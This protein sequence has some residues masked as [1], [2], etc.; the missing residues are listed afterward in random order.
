M[1]QAKHH[2]WVKQKKK[3]VEKGESVHS[4]IR[5]WDHNGPKAQISV[6]ET[7]A[8][9]LELTLTNFTQGKHDSSAAES[10]VALQGADVLLV[11]S[12]VLGFG[13]QGILLAQALMELNY[14]CCF[15]RLASTTSQLCRQRLIVTGPHMAPV[16]A[17]LLDFL[18]HTASHWSYTEMCLSSVT[19]VSLPYVA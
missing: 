11:R 5:S 18:F 16:N 12:T 15:Q 2:R 9:D 8:N 13:N 6:S 4:K 7:S 10:S 1:I 19:R 3:K 14:S 17:V